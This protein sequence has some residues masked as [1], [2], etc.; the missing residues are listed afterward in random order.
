M[1]YVL[2]FMAFAAIGLILDRVA[3]SQLRH[4]AASFWSSSNVNYRDTLF[5]RMILLPVGAALSAYAKGPDFGL[6]SVA[7]LILILGPL[8]ILILQLFREWYR[9]RP[10]P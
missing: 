6:L 3:F 10:R 9:A 8:A 7:G 1:T 4:A 2:D 5:P